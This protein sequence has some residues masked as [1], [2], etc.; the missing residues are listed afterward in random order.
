MEAIKEGKI[1]KFHTPLADENP[2]QLYVV[3]EV[4]EDNERSRAKIQA[5]NTGLT[6]APVN[7]VRLTDLEVSEVDNNDL[8]GHKVT[9][10][11]S[12]YSQVQGRVIKVSEQ[13]T[14]LN[15][16]VVERGVETNVLVTVVDHDGIEHFGTL[17]IDQE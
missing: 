13:K 14:E 17:F 3:L 6:F 7:T 8:I 2:N 1:V 5:L 9:I 11:K 16:C 12:D 4:I 15:L 10:N